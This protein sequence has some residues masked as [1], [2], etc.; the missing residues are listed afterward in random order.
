MYF[1]IIFAGNDYHF[2]TGG[3]DQ[4]QHG[5]YV[6]DHSGMSLSFTDWEPGQPG[7]GNEHCLVLDYR[8]NYTFH[9]YPCTHKLG[10]ICEKPLG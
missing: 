9:D 5:S 10:Y 4:Q 1:A 8:N 2:F 6:W 3:T 7:G